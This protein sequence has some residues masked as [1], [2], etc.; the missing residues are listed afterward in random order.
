MSKEGCVL[1][2]RLG[3]LARR[4]GEA[5]CR[6]YPETGPRKAEARLIAAM[7]AQ[8]Q[9]AAWVAILEEQ[10]PPGHLPP[11]EEQRAPVDHL[12]RFILCMDHSEATDALYE[13]GDQYEVEEH[14]QLN[15]LEAWIQRLEEI[16][17]G[18]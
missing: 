2:D 8:E 7:G 14:A 5:V 17:E 15:R 18:V 9:L 12:A 10:Y 13:M 3:G 16:L 11:N 1:E 6:L 4:L